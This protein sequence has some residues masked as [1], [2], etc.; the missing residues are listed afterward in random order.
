M[1][2]TA[3]R[4]INTIPA[5]EALVEIPII[6]AIVY[7]VLRMLHGTRGA[8]VFKGLVFLFTILAILLSL[9]ISYMHLEQV[10]F[11][12]SGFL[13]TPALALIILFQPEIR[14][15]LIRLGHAPLFR[16]LLWQESMVEQ[17]AEAAVQAAR[18]KIGLLIAV[19]RDVGLDDFIERGTRMDA[20]VTAELLMTIFWPDTPLSDGGIV[21]TNQRIAAAGCIFPLSDDPD[22]DKRL[23]TRHRAA[24]G[25][26]E[27]TDAVCVVVSEET[28]TISLAVHGQLVRSLDKETLATRLRR[29]VSMPEPAD[30]ARSTP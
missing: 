24:I 20:E 6:A 19:Q 21:I 30:K 29:L 8:G 5:P 9:V 7:L 16:G 11:F 14:R 18:Q 13:T 22:I 23:G 3:H 26:T 25:L 28:G 27:D 15:G 4:L 10:S 2:E 1:F 17:V 12:L